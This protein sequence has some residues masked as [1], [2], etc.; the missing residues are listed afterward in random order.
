EG[1]QVADD[2]RRQS[3]PSY[4][5]EAPADASLARLQGHGRYGNGGRG[6]QGPMRPTAPS[7]LRGRVSRSGPNREDWWSTAV[8]GVPVLAH[9]LPNKLV[10]A[11][12][13]CTGNAVVP[14]TLVPLLTAIAD[15]L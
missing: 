10:E 15:M 4:V 13:R 8:T 6:R 12:S 3:T 9:G 5:R 7:D 1:Q 11:V 2:L 14:Q